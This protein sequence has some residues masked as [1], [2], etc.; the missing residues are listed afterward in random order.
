M[1]D[2]NKQI[3]ESMQKTITLMEETIAKQEE[4]LKTLSWKIKENKARL[5]LWKKPAPEFK[6]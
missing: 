5:K 3:D 6:E 2:L 1:N 4:E